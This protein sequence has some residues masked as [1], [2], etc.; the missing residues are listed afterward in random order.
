MIMGASN[1]VTITEN[2]VRLKL[3]IGGRKHGLKHLLLRHFCENC[4]G[5]IFAIDIISL[6]RFLKKINKFNAH[7]NKTGYYYEKDENNKYRLL[8]FKDINS[9]GVISMFRLDRLTSQVESGEG[10]NSPSVNP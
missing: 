9:E 8:V 3:S 4:E 5:R 10:T 2:D 6:E 1:S 7:N